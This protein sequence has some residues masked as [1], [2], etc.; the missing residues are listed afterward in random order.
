M[1]KEQIIFSI[2][3][4]LA[5]IIIANVIAAIIVNYRKKKRKH[6]H[7]GIAYKDYIPGGSYCKY[8]PNHVIKLSPVTKDDEISFKCEIIKDRQCNNIKD[9]VA[10][11]YPEIHI[12]KSNKEE[13]Y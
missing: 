9:F 12:E 4:L 5:L 1:N 3:I 13:K 6:L 11:F 8:D 2:I 10:D 7:E